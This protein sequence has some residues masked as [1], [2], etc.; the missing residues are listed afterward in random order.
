[1]F[2]LQGQPSGETLRLVVVYRWPR[3]VGPDYI[4][5][6]AKEESDCTAEVESR[7]LRYVFSASAYFDAYL[8]DTEVRN[9][10]Y[11]YLRGVRT[12]VAF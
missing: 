8:H 5:C 10:E 4:H 7:P 11:G 1:M 6:T 2:P 12:P 3:I 9:T